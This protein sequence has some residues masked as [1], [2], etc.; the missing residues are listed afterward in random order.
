MLTWLN[1]NVIFG[2]RYWIRSVISMYII[3]NQDLETFP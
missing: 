1:L 3:E 2:V